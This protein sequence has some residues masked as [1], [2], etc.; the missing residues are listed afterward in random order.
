MPNTYILV[1]I[2]S[3]HQFHYQRAPQTELFGKLSV[4]IN[5]LFELNSFSLP[6]FGL[7]V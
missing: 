6:G 3:L 5:L 4:D 1:V 7:R 2:I